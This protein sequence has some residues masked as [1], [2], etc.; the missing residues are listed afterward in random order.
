MDSATVETTPKYRVSSGKSLRMN[1]VWY[2]WTNDMNG[3]YV[4]GPFKTE[5]AAMKRLAKLEKAD[6][7]AAE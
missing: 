2:I 4:A 7:A 3:R 6:A 5:A 1:A